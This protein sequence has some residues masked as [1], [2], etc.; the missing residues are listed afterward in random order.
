MSGPQLFDG[1]ALAELDARCRAM[2][3][4]LLSWTEE[5]KAH[6]VRLS[7]ATP[8]SKELDMRRELFGTSMESLILAKRLLACVCEAERI[9]LEGEAQALALL[10]FDLQKQ[11]SPKHS[12]LFTGHEVGVAYTVSLTR[13]QWEE[14]V[15]GTDIEKRL[16]ARNR[17]VYWNELLRTT[18]GA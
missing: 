6:C 3:K 8:T 12:W 18:E 4:G 9:K 14:E 7:L 13:D 11:P 10:I 16:A 1:E 5:Y 15:P 17:Y 2:Q